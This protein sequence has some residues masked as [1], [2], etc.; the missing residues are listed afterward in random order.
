[1]HFGRTECHLGGIEFIGFRLW[2]CLV[3]L[4]GSRCVCFVGNDNELR[5]LGIL[6][7]DNVAEGFGAMSSCT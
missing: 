6:D 2:L 1:M 3:Y 7:C 5:I 4:G